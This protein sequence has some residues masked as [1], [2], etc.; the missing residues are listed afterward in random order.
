MTENTGEPE[1]RDYKAGNPSDEP[2][3]SGDEANDIRFSEEQQLIREQARGNMPQ[4][5]DVPR[6]Y[7]DVDKAMAGMDV[8]DAELT[9]D[10]SNSPPY[11]GQEE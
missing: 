1:E 10:A 5:D 8:P 3:D 11:H 9:S 4:E 2:R 7:A 6:E